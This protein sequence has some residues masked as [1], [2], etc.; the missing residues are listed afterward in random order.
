MVLKSKSEMTKVLNHE[1]L[2]VWLSTTMIQALRNMITLFTHY[3]ESLQYMLD[4]FLDLLA[5]C[6]CQENDT[7]ARIGSNCLQQLILQNVSRFNPAH[8]NKI[9]GS[10][11]ELF[12]RTTAHRLFQAATS[13][14]DT[15]QIGDDDDYSR[16][17]SHSETAASV[18]EL[19]LST[20]PSGEVVPTLSTAD[21]QNGLP[22]GVNRSRSGSTKTET[23]PPQTPNL[24]D[25]RPQSALHKQPKVVTAARRKFFNKIITQCVLQLLM[26]ET[27]N[28]L[29]SNDSV[30]KAIPSG[31]L[32]R[33]MALLKGSYH[34]AK[35]FNNDRKLRM[36]LWHEGFMKQPPNLLKQ[37]SGSA[38]CYIAILLRMYHDEGE[39]RR[40]SRADTESALIPYVFRSHPLPLPPF[41]PIIQ[42]CYYHIRNLLEY[43]PYKFPVALVLRL[44][45]G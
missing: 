21:Q 23:S 1:D 34:F 14:S 37:E 31:E 43:G 22:N 26:I 7:I 38:A 8:W 2:S 44:S 24:E 30:Y 28:E 40:R 10:F 13:S 35:R 33:L 11:V 36:D 32:L 45:A 41:P 39:E 27:V 42:P 15:S 5:L 19:T 20:H 3:F 6:I 29:F 17:A 9:V 25:Y 4:R 18:K 16:K 12:E